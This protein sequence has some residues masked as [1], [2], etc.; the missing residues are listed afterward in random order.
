MNQKFSPDRRSIHC[1]L[2]ALPEDF[3][4]ECVMRMLRMEPVQKDILEK[5]E[6][7]LRTEFMSATRLQLARTRQQPSQQLTAD[8]TLFYDFNP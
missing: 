1:V 2:G 6:R 8:S 7:T 5:V 4:L 3:A